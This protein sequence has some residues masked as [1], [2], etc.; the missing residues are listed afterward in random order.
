MHE[1]N[2]AN[3]ASEL[4]QCLERTWILAVVA[5]DCPIPGAV[6]LISIVRESDA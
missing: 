6:G 1:A 2:A 3:D 4:G 5:A